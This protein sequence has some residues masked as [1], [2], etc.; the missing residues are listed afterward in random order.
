[1]QQVSEHSKQLIQRYT[2]A[3]EHSPIPI[4]NIDVIYD[5]DRRFDSTVRYDS[6]ISLA[7]AYSP[8]IEQQLIDA[9]TFGVDNKLT[10]IYFCIADIPESDYDRMCALRDHHEISRKTIADDNLMSKLVCIRNMTSS[11]NQYLL[12]CQVDLLF[13]TEIVIVDDSLDYRH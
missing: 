9:V 1:M 10:K 8:N 5:I 12:K 7:C 11:I 6:I 13:N 2:T 3:R 4:Y